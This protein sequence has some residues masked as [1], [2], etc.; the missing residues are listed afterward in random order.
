M[1][2]NATSLKTVT[3]PTIAMSL[4]LPVATSAIAIAVFILDTM[5]Q[6]ETSFAV[7]YVGVV[8]LSA[9]FLQKRGVVL[10]SLGCMALT[11][12][13]QQLH[14]EI[15]SPSVALENC[16]LSL[17]AIG[18]SA[19]LAVQ[20]Q[21]RELVLREQSGLLDLTHDTVFVRDINDVITYWNRGAEE[22]YGWKRGEAVGK[23]T[24]QLMQTIFPMPL[25]AIPISW[26]AFIGYDKPRPNRQRP[27]WRRARRADLHRVHEGGAQRRGAEGIPSPA[28]RR[29][30]FR[31]TGARVLARPRAARTLSSKPSSPARAPPS[32]YSVIGY[33]D[34][35]GNSG[36]DLA[37]SGS[38]GVFR[39]PASY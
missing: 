11:V 8:L 17:A 10:A 27:D 1:N 15:V 21:S 35:M 24:H 14:D 2:D 30:A 7:L 3:S 36:I 31:S 16:L 18:I 32:T 12:L 34:T 6:A 20:S 23:I 38:C 19:F 28:R 39:E 22:L 9:R 4:V 25:E 13:S 29:A 26:S 33:Q 5:T 37:G